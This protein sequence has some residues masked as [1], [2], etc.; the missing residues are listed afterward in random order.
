MR[1]RRIRLPLGFQSI[2]ETLPDRV[3]A[4]WIIVAKSHDGV[5]DHAL[6]KRRLKLTI[7]TPEGVGPLV[8]GSLND[9]R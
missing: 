7:G 6:A 5:L 4:V 3:S 8:A 9:M 2:V 1:V